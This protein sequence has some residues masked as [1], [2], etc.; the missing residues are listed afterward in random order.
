MDT[1]GSRNG[2]AVWGT[3]PHKTSDQQREQSV[4]D[5]AGRKH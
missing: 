4:G 2:K 1:T 3:L 5:A